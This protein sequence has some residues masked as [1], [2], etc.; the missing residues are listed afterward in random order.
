MLPFFSIVIPVYNK[1]NHIKATLESVLN[2][3]FKDFEVIIVNDGSSDN[4]ENIIRQI[5]DECIRLYTIENHGVSFA[6]NYGIS[7]AKANF[8]ALLDADDIWY[9]NHLENLKHLIENFPNCGLYC[10]AYETSYYDK[11]I[12]K[13]K[14]LGIGVS[15]YGIVPDY[16]ASSLVNSIAWS[17]AVVIPKTILEKHGCFNTIIRSGQDT[18]L[19][20]RIAVKEDVA[21]SS[22]ISTRRVISDVGNHLSHSTKRIDRLKV[23]EQFAEYEKTNQSLKKYMD[24]NR[25]SIAVERKMNGDTESFKKI[26]KDIKFTNL[27][28]KQKV[29]LKLP[30]FV[31]NL[32]KQFQ[33]FLIKHDIYLTPFR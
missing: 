12:V 29:I 21:F 4:S 31:L 8:I 3:S 20:I 19:W 30:R 14:F 11:K 27:N 10:T 22:K 15:F 26:I 33:V 6:R 2:Q 9:P 23:L 13:G 7:K 16:F 28:A 17:S 32:L 25:F 1:E 5:N 24:L 18:E